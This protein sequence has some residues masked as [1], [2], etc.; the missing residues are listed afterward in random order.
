M[1]TKKIKDELK[2]EYRNASPEGQQFL[3]KLL[4]EDLENGQFI[5]L[6]N[7]SYFTEKGSRILG[8]SI[9][10]L[11]LMLVLSIYPVIIYFD[12]LDEFHARISASPTPTAYFSLL[13]YW[14]GAGFVLIA[15]RRS[16]RIMRLWGLS[17]ILGAI[18]DTLGY[19][20][21]FFEIRN[22]LY[23]LNS[24]H[25]LHFALITYIF[26]VW[27]H[28]GRLFITFNAIN[29]LL[30]IMPG[31]PLSS[32]YYSVV[33]VSLA[34]YYLVPKQV[35]LKDPEIVTVIASILFNLGLFIAVFYQAGLPKE[36]V[37]NL[38]VVVNITSMIYSL[39]I[40]YATFFSYSGFRIRINRII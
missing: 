25:I 32:I 35:N 4:E 12:L 23:I 29:V 14:I 11:F 34:V 5:S 36:T 38:S 9:F 7:H 22:P 13:L 2:E 37:I 26:K 15:W 31:E 30:L 39:A 8:I 17:I 33:T 16:N 20:N 10:A 18:F 6:A 27:L 40:I 1:S 24:Y 3:S 28:I 21:W 19:F